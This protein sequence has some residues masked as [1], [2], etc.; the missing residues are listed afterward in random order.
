MQSETIERERR[1]LERCQRRT[2]N[3]CSKY[4]YHYTTP[5]P[6][7]HHCATMSSKRSVYDE[8]DYDDYADEDYYGDYGDFDPGESQVAGKQLAKVLVRPWQCTILNAQVMLTF[9]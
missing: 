1:S 9:I 4:Q 3:I 8:D 7:L 6:K 5:R 2:K